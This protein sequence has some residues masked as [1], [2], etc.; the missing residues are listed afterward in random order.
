MS[1]GGGAKVSI[2]D[3]LLLERTAHHCVLDRRLEVENRHL[4]N[5]LVALDDPHALGAQS[6]HDRARKATDEFSL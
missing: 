3:S 1:C 4:C 6:Q 2:V 5:F